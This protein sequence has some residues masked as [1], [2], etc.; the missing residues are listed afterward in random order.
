MFAIRDGDK[1]AAAYDVEYIPGLMV[2]DAN[3]T[4]AYRRAWT[5]LPAGSAVASAWSIQVRQNLDRL[6]Q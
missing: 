5:E 2:I 4:I 6:L 3:G 1:I